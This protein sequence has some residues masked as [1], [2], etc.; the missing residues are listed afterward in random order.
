ML[1]FCSWVS[2]QLCVSNID[3]NGT[4]LEY[5]TDAE[6][7]CIHTHLRMLCF[8]SHMF[9]RSLSP[10][11]ACA[12][13]SR[14]Q[15]PVIRTLRVSPLSLWRHQ[16]ILPVERAPGLPSAATRAWVL[17]N[18]LLVWN[19]SPPVILKTACA[20][21]VAFG[22]LATKNVR[23]LAFSSLIIHWLLGS[24]REKTVLENLC[25]WQFG[26]TVIHTE[27]NTS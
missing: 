16:R 26:S 25:F 20:C 5:F 14:P 3:C 22:R 12:P 10:G 2:S 1:V 4:D 6:T 11:S 24:S 8:C 13:F 21:T 19:Q 15:P 17:G 18:P 27:F 9:H 7:S 23:I